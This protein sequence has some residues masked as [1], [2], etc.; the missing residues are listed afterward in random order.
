MSDAQREFSIWVIRTLREAGFTALWAGGCVRDR[1]LGREPKDYDVATA[2]HPDQVLELFRK[3]HVRSL[4]IGV[5]FGVVALVG[6]RGTGT[7]EVATFREDASYSDGRHPDAVQFS[8]PQRDAQR[9]DFTINGL[10][11]DP[12]EE[13]IL[14][15]VGGQA[16][17]A[18]GV[19]RAIREPTERFDEDKLRMLRAVRFA[20]SL[21]FQIESAT[22]SAIQTMASQI[23]CVSAERIAAEM[24]RVLTGP[25]R[26]LGLR[27]LAQSELG[28]E[29]LPELFGPLSHDPTLLDRWTR[30]LE[31]LTIPDV[32]VS[33][34][35]LAYGLLTP[36]TLDRI[37]K[38]WKWANVQRRRAVW[39]LRQIDAVDAAA[40]KVS[41][42]QPLFVAPDF[43]ALLQLR[44][45]FAQTNEMPAVLPQRIHEMLQWSP[46][47]LAPPPLLDGNILLAHG[48]QPGVLIKQILQVVRDAQ[49]DGQITTTD[50]AITLAF[51]M[52]HTDRCDT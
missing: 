2:A 37:A 52:A 30:R 49:L 40:Q 27:L 34:A 26:G 25:N 10:F 5:S 46:E 24:D 29:I 31:N 17:L 20:T 33:M 48:F 21:G 4:P 36:N 44:Q 8:T 35:A 43:D 50:Q 14:D 11:F 19:L 22:F 9:R 28:R 39:C 42:L 41:T 32:S 51:A 38:R 45:L 1:L 23:R 18:A 16:D 6:P 3:R 15:F 47:Q 13:K 7:V 12:I